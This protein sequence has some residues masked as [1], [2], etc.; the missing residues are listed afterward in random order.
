MA[1]RLRSKRS[2]SMM[3]AGVSTSA[4]GSPTCAGMHAATG[5]PLFRRRSFERCQLPV[6]DPGERQKLGPVEIARQRITTGFVIDPVEDADAVFK[7]VAECS[8]TRRL[9]AFANEKRNALLVGVF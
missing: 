7:R 9:A 2:R 1:A 4:R 6:D 3:S 8:F 5:G